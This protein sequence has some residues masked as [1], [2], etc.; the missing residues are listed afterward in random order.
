MI[1]HARTNLIAHARTHAHRMNEYAAMIGPTHSTQAKSLGRAEEALTTKSQRQG[2]QLGIKMDQML[3][4][5]L[6]QQQERSAAATVGHGNSNNAA[7][8]ATQQSRARSSNKAVAPLLSPLGAGAS[9][10]MSQLSSPNEPQP[11]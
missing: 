11:Q 5:L 8:M 1:V 9:K 10:R 6:E 7:A 2:A 4:M 3:D